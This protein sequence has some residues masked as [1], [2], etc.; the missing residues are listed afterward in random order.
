MS[1]KIF[2]IQGHPDSSEAHF[3]HALEHSYADAAEAAGHSV[4]RVRIAGLDFPLLHSEK[5]FH[6]EL[7]PALRE[8]REALLWA[9]HLVLIY[10]LWLGTMP[11]LVKAWL[12]Q[13]FRP[14]I[15]LSEPDATSAWPRALLKDKS[16]RVVVTMGMPALAYRWFYRA[17]SLKSLE[18][19]ILRFSGVGPISETLIG[20][21]AADNPRAREKYLEKMR[22]LGQRGR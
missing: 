18:R 2:V 3:C 10:P 22:E 21:V 19:N 8:S 12:E 11:A 5:E 20:M 13:L 1:R 14:G 6:G 4:R 15:A 16:S 7:P 9:E 17:H